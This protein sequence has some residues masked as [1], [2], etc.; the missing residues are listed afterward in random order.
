MGRPALFFVE[1]RE[2]ASAQLGVV[3]HHSV[4][5]LYTAP[6]KRLKQEEYTCMIAR[7]TTH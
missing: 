6:R 5:D 4:S 2:I 7:A 3:L 1:E